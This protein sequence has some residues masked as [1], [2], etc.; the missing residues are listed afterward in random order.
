MLKEAQCQVTG[1][2]NQ[3]IK[4]APLIPIPV[5]QEP[6]H[7]VIIDTVEP[8]PKT[9]SGN[10]NLL[11]I[12]CITSKLIIKSL[13]QFFAQY[14]IP[15]QIQSDQ[16]SPFTSNV[17]KQVMATAY[18]PESQGALERFHQ[19]YKNML[20]KYCNENS[21][22]WDEGVHFVL[23]VIRSSKQE[24]LGL[25]PF[26]LVFGHEVRGPLKVLKDSWLDDKPQKS[27]LTYV[28][29]FKEIIKKALEFARSKLEK[30]Q[31]HMKNKFDRNLEFSEFKPDESSVVS[32]V[33][34][35]PDYSEEHAEFQEIQINNEMK[36]QNSDILANPFKKIHHLS[37][38]QAE[39][40]RC[41]LQDFPQLFV[42]IPQRCR[43]VQHDVELVEGA[44]PI[45]QAPYHMNPA[46]RELLEQEVKFLLAY[47]FVEKSSSEWASP[48][49]LV[50]KPIGSSRMCADYRRMKSITKTDSYSIPRID[51]IIDNL[52]K[53]GLDGVQS[54]LDDL[55]VY[56]ST[57]E[58]HLSRLRLLFV[59]LA[60]ACLTIN[61]L[62]S[63]FAHAKLVYLGH[64][65]G[66]SEVSPVAGKVEAIN[67][68]PI[69]ETP[70]GGHEVSGY[71][72][73]LQTVLP[74]L[75]QVVIP[76]TDLVSP[77]KKFTWTPA[78]QEAFNKMRILLTNAPVLQAPD[79][80]QPFILQ[81][82]ASDLEAVAV[83]LQEGADEILHPVCYASTKFKKHQKNYAT[84]EKE[85][86]AL[87]YGLDKINVNL[88]SS[89]DS[90]I[91]YTDHNPLKFINKMQNKNQRLM[92]W[93]LA[94]QQY[95]WAIKHIKGRDNIIADVLSKQSSSQLRTVEDY[96]DWSRL[97]PSLPECGL[98]SVPA[99]TTSRDL[100]KVVKV[101]QDSPRSAPR[102]TA[103]RRLVDNDNV[104]INNLYRIIG[105]L[106]FVLS[107]NEPLLKKAQKK[108][109]KVGIMLVDYLEEIAEPA[110]HTPR[111]LSVAPVTSSKEKPQAITGTKPKMIRF[112]KVCKRKGHTIEKCWFARQ[113]DKY[114]AIQWQ[115]REKGSSQDFT[116]S[117][118]HAKP[119]IPRGHY[120]GNKMSQNTKGTPNKWCVIQQSPYHNTEDCR[121]I[122]R[123]TQKIENR[124]ETST[125]PSGEEARV[126]QHALG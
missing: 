84:I 35:S 110:E 61:L 99:N 93:S 85:C 112:C 50:P 75:S 10:Q 80:S 17:F 14:G 91:V 9:R 107:P 77:K 102:L 45:K 5:S 37:S 65:V 101:V 15:S 76:L 118:S 53:C 54:Y 47:N 122:Q 11:T 119:K 124:R 42:D 2:P 48:C 29:Q 21:V 32:V 40:V 89:V 52:V 23:S 59:S 56:S 24:S 109:F 43:L 74:N 120:T 31:S 62:K 60:E 16:D 123:M 121:K 20:T 25:S 55:N 94:S 41:L 97:L 34:S 1:T 78:C 86:T 114:P 39:D 19:T 126:Q 108:E 3:I 7:K 79:F 30:V 66:F 71:G 104:S 72:W 64:I 69:P 105:F 111:A 22:D 57:W 46:K 113:A 92:R 4:P 49:L 33:L 18:H 117:D 98:R 68:L 115:D 125:L 70:K 8:L 100:R 67:N 51:D 44:K 81:V 13:T 82:D 116:N 106:Q 95:K 90:I 96:P 36:L 73:I 6:F 58:E 63:K 87:L 26:E 88:S 103:P 27:L 83:L 12:R 28:T 38:D